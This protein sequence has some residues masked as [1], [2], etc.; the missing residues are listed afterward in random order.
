M[1]YR[2]LSEAQAEAYLE[3]KRSK[4]KGMT[5]AQVLSAVV[6]PGMSQRAVT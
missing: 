6:V 3:E 2:G 1:K 5:V 4:G